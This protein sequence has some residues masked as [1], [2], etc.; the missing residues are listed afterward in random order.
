[1]TMDDWLNVYTHHVPE[2]IQQMQATHAAW[3]AEKQGRRPDPDTSLF[4]FSNE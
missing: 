4:K 2:H 1:M 3:L